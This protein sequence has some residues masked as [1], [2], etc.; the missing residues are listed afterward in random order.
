MPAGEKRA[1]PGEF[2]LLAR[3]QA[4]RDVR[5]IAQLATGVAAPAVRDAAGHDSARAF[6]AGRERRERQRRR[7]YQNRHRHVG[8]I[9]LTELTACVAAPAPDLPAGSARAGVLPA[10]RDLHE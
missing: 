8:R 2:S 9:A 10:C 1:P 7:L 3:G 6:L 4:L 5:A